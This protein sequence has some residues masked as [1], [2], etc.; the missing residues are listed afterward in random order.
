MPCESRASLN[1]H[2]RDERLG[3]VV[4]RDGVWPDIVRALSHAQRVSDYIQQGPVQAQREPEATPERPDE[5]LGSIA[6]KASF[7]FLA[8]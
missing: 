4:L 1:R 8:G 6:I 7:I 2:S 5:P 3:A